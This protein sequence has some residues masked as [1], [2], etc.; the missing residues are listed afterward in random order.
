MKEKPMAFE[1]FWIS[2]R[3]AAGPI[4]R[5]A[6]VVD[7]PRLDPNEI[8]RTLRAEPTMWL[9]PRA[10]AGFDVKDLDFLPQAE[11]RRMAK[12]VKDFQTLTSGLNPKDRAADE[13]VERALAMFRDIIVLLEFNRYEDPEAFRL[14]KQIEQAIKAQWPEELAELR[15]STALDHTGDPGIWIWV[16]L[17]EEASTTDDEFLENAK[18]LRHWLDT[19]A[20]EIAPE[21]YPYLSF[22]SIAE[23]VD[24]A[25]AS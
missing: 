9:T 3:R 12:L 13:V 22:R 19:I 14:G 10:V 25:D 4:A 11:R 8:D 1:D 21:R 17:T 7:L 23:E 2:V 16:F 5:Q 18:R 15:F 24:L 6:R 20:R